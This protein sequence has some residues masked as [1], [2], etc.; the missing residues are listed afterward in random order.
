MKEN[1][2]YFGRSVINSYAVLFFSQ[3]KILGVILLAVSFFNVAAGLA[4]LLCTVFAIICTTFT[5][6]QKPEIQKGLLSFNALLFGL[7]FGTFFHANTAFFIWLTVGCLVCVLITV[8][9][10]SWLALRGLPVLSVPFII[11]FWILLSAASGIFQMGLSQKSSSILNE[12]ATNSLSGTGGLHLPYY[13]DLYCRALSAVLFQNNVLSGLLISLG[14]LIHSRIAFT[15]SIIGFFSVCLFNSLT[16]TYPDGPSY[17]HLG[18]NFMMAAMAIG[19]FFLVPGYRSYLWAMVTVPVIFLL[20]NAFTKIF[21]GYGLPVLSLPFCIATLIILYFFIHQKGRLKAGLTPLQYYSPEENLYQY[22]NGEERLNDF[23]Y[24]NI[25]PPFMGSWLVSQGYNGDITH[26]DEWG[27]AL[28]FVI[29]DDDA[30]TYKFPG[31]KLTDFYCFGKPVLA[32]GDGVIAEMVNHIDDNEIGT[33]NTRENWG[34]TIVIRHTN[35]L[36]SKV[37]HL[38]KNSAKVKVGDFVKQGDIIAQCGSSGRSPEPHLHFQLQATAFIGSKTLAYPFSYYVNGPGNQQKLVSYAVPKEGDTIHPLQVNPALKAAFTF[39]PG[40][41]ATITSPQ[42]ATEKFEVYTDLLNQ[43]YMYSKTTASAAYF[44]NNGTSF[45]FTTFYGDKN[46]LLYLFYLAA[47]KVVFTD[48]KNNEA[49][50]SYPLQLFPAR[51]VRWLNDLVAPFMQFIRLDYQSSNELENERI[52]I[53]ANQYKKVSGKRQ[54]TM[55]ASVTVTE[56]NIN[57]F[58]INFNGINTEATWAAG[59]MG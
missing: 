10:W 36:F 28:D 39:Q 31:V 8:N 12:L 15:V 22:L 21:G 37:S 57:S 48:D 20:I 27:Q 45:Y 59:N 41:I 11:S 2:T 43:T 1:L 4:G 46:S 35:G 29:Q 19:S 17:Y 42:R 56:G 9:L 30:H 54:Q 32:C 18:S 50:D 23:K 47:Y 34:N 25:K 3:N 6:Y 7:G 26:K 14:L 13:I 24:F 53:R 51:P 55:T 40:F 49:T 58:N 16:G 38:K 52:T 5:G 44:V 33:V